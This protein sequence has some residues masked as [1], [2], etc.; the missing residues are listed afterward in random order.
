MLGYY[1]NNQIDSGIHLFNSDRL[2]TDPSA[3]PNN[4]YN[5]DGYVLISSLDRKEDDEDI[6]SGILMPMQPR[7]ILQNYKTVQGAVKNNCLYLATGTRYIYLYESIEGSEVKLNASIVEPYETNGFDKTNIG[8]NNISPFPNFLMTDT[9]VLATSRINAI[10]NE[11]QKIFIDGTGS[12]TGTFKAIMDYIENTIPD[13]YYFRWEYRKKGTSDWTIVNTYMNGMGKNIVEDVPFSGLTN[14]DIIEIKCSYANDFKTETNDTGVDTKITDG[15]SPED[16]VVNKAFAEFGQ[17]VMEYE[18]VEGSVDTYE[19]E[20]SIYFE[21]I[22]TCNKM[23]M[24]GSMLILY[25][26]K[27]K[28]GN[29]Y[30]SILDNFGY[31]TTRNSLNFQTNKNE[32]IVACLALEDNIIVF[33]DNEHLGGS[34]HKVYGNGDDY[35]AG[36]GYFS[37][38]KKTIVNTTVSCDHPNSVQFVKNFIMF[39]YRDNV[40]II[41]TND[42]NDKRLMVTKATTQISHS[43]P[44]VKMPRIK[45]SDNYE[46]ELFSEITDDYYG[47]IFP[48]AKERWKMYFNMGRNYDERPG[49]YFP[50][51]RD[52]GD[53]FE[54]KNVLTINNISTHLYDNKLIQYIDEDYKDLGEP[55]K[56]K[57]LLKAFDMYNPALVKFIQSVV[58]YY[59]RGA[60]DDLSLD[61]KIYN[62]GNYLLMGDKSI[63]FYDEEKKA[64]IYDNPNTYYTDNLEELD[65]QSLVIDHNSLEKGIIGKDL[66][67]SKTFRS[68]LKFPCLNAYVE[69]VIDSAEAF[70]L[71]SLT[72]NYVTTDMPK[73]SLPNIYAKIIRDD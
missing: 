68:A 33:A 37:P 16:W 9:Y 64:I 15:N 71:S 63:S 10:L 55:F 30:K 38:F 47:I 60:T 58:L 7:L 42:L 2:K 66:L 62:E 54:I 21:E 26:S 56:T 1:Q 52:E 31:I 35:D 50:W 24:T 39:K 51:L 57:F 11:E 22:Q 25:G 45:Y 59:Y 29:W 28:N 23:F 12:G 67:T 3:I 73:K 70:S 49:V 19:P 20:P 41:N 6:M 18:V 13:D 8:N 36:N 61:F 14:G 5:H 53:I 32:R 46:Y 34:I 65:K 27:S 4:L 44:D 72:F 69:I 17:V 48:K 40:Y 43:S